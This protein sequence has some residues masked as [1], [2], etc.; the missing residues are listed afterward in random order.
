MP[1][2]FPKATRIMRS[3]GTGLFAAM[4][5][6]MGPLQPVSAR[7]DTKLI[8]GLVGFPCGLNAFATTQC[9]GFESAKGKLPEGYTFE[10]KTG[11]DFADNVSFNNL[12]ETTLQ[13]KPAG[14]VVFP[15][16]ASSQTQ[17][18]LKA[19]KQGVKIIIIDVAAEGLGE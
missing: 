2:L 17:V 4:V 18:L 1:K 15:G 8:V 14:I 7:A 3:I 19:C 9:S 12:I 10:L 16:G 11:L 13:L 5:I 6:A